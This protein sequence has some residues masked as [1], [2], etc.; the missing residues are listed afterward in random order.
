MILSHLMIGISFW[1][2]LLALSGFLFS[3]HY[4]RWCSS[5]LRSFEW[6]AEEVAQIVK[7]VKYL[8]CFGLATMGFAIMEH[9]LTGLILI[10]VWIC[11]DVFVVLA[12]MTAIYIIVGFAI[13]A[14]THLLRQR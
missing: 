7:V 6:S 4:R 3:Y 9:F 5:P 14:C 10:P 8:V 11:Y 2:I 1:S 12:A 13:V